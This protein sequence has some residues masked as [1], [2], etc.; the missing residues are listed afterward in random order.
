MILL[1][2]LLA[3][4]GSIPGLFGIGGL[5]VG[6]AVFALELKWSRDLVWIFIAAAAVWFVLGVTYR[7]GEKA[8]RESSA[9][10]Q[11]ADAATVAVTSARLDA[12]DQQNKAL[13]VDVDRYAAEIAARPV[14]KRCILDQHD[15][16]EI[17]R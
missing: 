10:V 2:L 12:L 16:D 4:A 11:A 3:I 7:E 13:A 14:E 1:H 9:A 5:F 6:L 8:C 15:A 17:N